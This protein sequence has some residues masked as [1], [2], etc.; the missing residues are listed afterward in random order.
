MLPLN[1]RTVDAHDGWIRA[2]DIS[3]DRQTIATVGNDRLVK[4][5][6]AA[7]GEDIDSGEYFLLLTLLFLIDLKLDRS[8]DGEVSC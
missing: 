2:V 7:D 1:A 8:G 6:R 4:L 3:P 5:W